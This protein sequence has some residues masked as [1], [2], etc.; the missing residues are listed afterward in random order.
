VIVLP[1]NTKSLGKPLRVI[2]MSLFD[3][4]FERDSIAAA[5]E[6]RDANA[7]AILRTRD[8]QHAPQGTGRVGVRKQKGGV[9]S[10]AASGSPHRSLFQCPGRSRL[11]PQA[12][13]AARGVSG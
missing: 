3:G 11:L 10:L 12:I 6:T 8:A 13:Q 7:A 2:A 4:T 9:Q 5:Q 1:A